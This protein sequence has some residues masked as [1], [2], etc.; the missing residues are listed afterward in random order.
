M[1][2]YRPL[3]ILFAA[4][5]ALAWAAD[6]RIKNITSTA[7][8]PAGDDYIALDGTTNGTRKILGT[9]FL[10]A[11]PEL[12]T[13][14]SGSFVLNNA[15]GIGALSATGN[16]TVLIGNALTG[17]FAEAALS[18]STG[19]NITNGASSIS[20]AT[21]GNFAAQNIVTTGNVTG[22][23]ITGNLVST[24]ANIT[25]INATN[26]SGA[27]AD[28]QLLVGNVTSGNFTKQ[29][30]S[31][32]IAFTAAGVT[33]VKDVWV[34]PIGD[35]TTALTTGTAKVTFRAPY[36]C[37]VT[38][39]RASL[40]TV[41]SSGTPTFDINEGGTTILSTK[42]TIDAS[43]KT[44]TTAATAAVISDSSLAD[45][46]EITIDIDTAGT[47]A[48]GAKIYIYVTR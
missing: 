14:T 42:L 43:E 30:P 15:T 2:Q 35:E 47:S 11:A 27:T 31:G 44:S 9:K 24:T 26:I 22:N 21:S 41:S 5:A 3:L 48:A 37:T 23:I 39:V 45:D 18:N 6:V 16:G 34:I 33:T 38:A 20:I 12:T 25:T 1:K 13:Y 10:L 36:A 32:A 28:G 4:I 46:A 19:I 7:T 40:T 17:F 8:T 29:T